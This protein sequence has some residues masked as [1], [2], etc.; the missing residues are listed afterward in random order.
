[1]PVYIG[2]KPLRQ[3]SEDK[4]YLF[5]HILLYHFKK[6]NQKKAM[7]SNFVVVKQQKLPMTLYDK[8]LGRFRERNERQIL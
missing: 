4:N 2:T 8:P 1:M 7:K 5:H 3:K 6:G